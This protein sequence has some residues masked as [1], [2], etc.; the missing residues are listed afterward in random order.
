MSAACNF[1]SHPVLFPAYDAIKWNAIHESF[2]NHYPNVQLA[3]LYMRAIIYNNWQ[4]FK[5]EAEKSGIRASRRSL[6]VFLEIL[7]WRIYN[8]IEQSVSYN[9]KYLQKK[10]RRLYFEG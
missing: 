6:A 4:Y 2:R 1:L 8:L 10:R 3:Q 5:R 7:E 9:L